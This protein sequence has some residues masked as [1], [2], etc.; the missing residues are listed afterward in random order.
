MT[1]I[2]KAENILHIS[3]HMIQLEIIQVQLH[4]QMC[5][6]EDC[7]LK[8]GFQI[9]RWEIRH[10]GQQQ[11]ACIICVICYMIQIQAGRQHS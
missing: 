5:H 6:K 8:H 9:Q 4:Q 3:M 7:M 2:K 1:I 10:S 11:E